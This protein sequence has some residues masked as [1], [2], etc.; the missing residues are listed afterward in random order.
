MSTLRPMSP[1]HQTHHTQKGRPMSPSHQTHHTQKGRPMSPSHQTHHTQKGNT[2]RQRNM[3]QNVATPK[4]HILKYLKVNISLLTHNPPHIS[5]SL[6]TTLLT[7]LPPYT[8]PSHISPSLH[9]PLF[10]Y[11]PPYTQPSSHTPTV[12]KWCCFLPRCHLHTTHYCY[13]SVRSTQLRPPYGYSNRR[14]GHL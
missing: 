11:L 9:T 13:L 2:V 12:L 7:Y 10:T 1:S 5:P 6:H 8:H 3:N 14:A 4:A